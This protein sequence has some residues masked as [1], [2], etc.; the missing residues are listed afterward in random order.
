MDGAESHLWGV[1]LNSDGE[2]FVGVERN[3]CDG[4][5]RERGGYDL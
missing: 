4:E 5:E 1:A 3:G 2:F